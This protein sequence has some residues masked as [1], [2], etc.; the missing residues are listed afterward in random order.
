[1][2]K[3]YGCSAR[4]F[5]D[6]P[7]RQIFEGS[8]PPVRTIRDYQFL[9][10]RDKDKVIVYKCDK[11]CTQLLFRKTK[12]EIVYR[13]FIHIFISGMKSFMDYVARAS[14]LLL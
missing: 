1:M 3:V 9:D 4:I 13:H 5:K 6:Q 2:A 8:Y 10:K 12:T 14:C 11:G 7:G